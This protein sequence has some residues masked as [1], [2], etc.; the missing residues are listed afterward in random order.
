ME[1][2]LV[3]H[4]NESSDEE[5][6]ED[7]AFDSD[8]ERQYGSAF[9]KKNNNSDSE[10]SEK[11]QSD[12]DDDSDVFSVDDDEEDGD[13]GQFML[14]LLNNMDKKDGDKQEKADARK[15]MAHSNLIPESEYSSAVKSTNLTLSELMSNI[16][17]TK[18]F[19][20]V[21][22]AMKNMTSDLNDEEKRLSTTKTP[23]AKVVSERAERKVHYKEQKEE[24]S[25]W[26]EATKQ[27]REAETL[28]FRPNHRIK[29]TKD[30]LVGK[31]QPT[32]D[33]EK[34][35]A[36]ALEEAGAAD[37]REM[38]K[39][40]PYHFPDDEDDEDDDLGRGKL[41]AE[42]FK[43]RHVELS[44]MRSL[45]FYE[46][47]KRH[48][49][50]KIK[51]KKYRKIRSK[52]RMRAKDSE[53]AEAA[54]EDE[55]YAREL[56]EKGEM[57]RMK[58]RMSL[59]HRNTSKW[60]KRVLRRGKHVDMDTRKA[61]SEQVR[62]GDELK[63]KMEGHFS[64]E[65]D[66]EETNLLEQTRAILAETE[67][68]EN[69]QDEEK[70]LFSLDFM[71]KGLE[72][73]RERAKEE[74]RELLRELEANEMGSENEQEEMESGKGTS[75]GGKKKKSGRRKTAASAKEI[76]KV[77]PQGKLTA[78]A[79]EFGLSDAVT[80][81]GEID[82]NIDKAPTNG[83]ASHKAKNIILANVK[84]STIEKKDEK[85]ASRKK[86]QKKAM[87][88]SE[89]G[90]E[91]NP[92]IKATHAESNS[93]KQKKLKKGL[94]GVFKQGVINVADSVNVLSADTTSSRGK[95]RSNPA[96]LQT[97]M[98]GNPDVKIA[99]LSQEELVRKA[100][101]TPSAK[102]IDDDFEKEKEAIR[103]RED[104]TKKKKEDNSM[105]SGWGSW[106]GEGAPAPRPPK[107]LPKHLAAP[108][109]KKEK[110]RRKDDGKKNVIIAAKRVKKA[111]KFQMA[112]LPY[113]YS[114]REQ[115]DR[116]MG[117]AIGDEWN[118]SGA[119]KTFTRSEV[120]TRAGKIIKPMA[121]KAKTKRARAPL[122]KFK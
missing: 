37:E 106:A 88:I 78:K 113:P 7:M 13:G 114:S 31:F 118:V 4:V 82:L 64:D 99:T 43:K 5:I 100:F 101:A 32:T 35:M 116:A 84:D 79:L 68:E 107:K 75:S 97:A 25:Q 93:K 18:G 98:E 11:S 91:S 3:D 58:E 46:E 63:R 120:L 15:A 62:I 50:H 41:S 61:L 90:E 19:G 22:K 44:K 27:N 73:Q 111:A 9:A 115:Y 119:V 39:N 67:E 16:T 86:D 77:L 69:K 121:K 26:V 40:Q 71:K 51:S 33:F 12:D 108:Q 66:D 36:D 21:Q 92:W 85:K 104:P 38:A 117:G 112:N 57:E 30:E 6:D 20:T 29:I 81:S 14:D 110:R 8:D 83:S 52:Q 56:E 53:D 109:K 74:A 80:V 28:D 23:V 34:E 89:A 72:A 1:P 45:M 42:E 48:R 102:D 103:D 94:P 17:D 95:E 87:Q 122:V 54:E 96:D 2:R 47:Q 49:V 55:D 59:K 76:E 24:I 60:A 65:S 70:G 105:V 10:D